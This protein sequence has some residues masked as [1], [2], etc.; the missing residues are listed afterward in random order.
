[1]SDSNAMPILNVDVAII[2]GGPAGLMAAEVLSRAGLAVHLFDAMP[3]VGRKFLLAGKGGMNLTHAE[4]LETFVTRYGAAQDRVQALLQ[5]LGPP[6]VRDW[7][8]GLGIDDLRGHLEPRLP[9]RHES[10][11]PAARL[12]APAAPPG[13]RAV[14]RWCFTCATAGKAG[15]RRRRTAGVRRA[16]GPG[17][18]A[19]PRHRAR[20]G[21]RQ[22][23]PPGVRWCLGAMA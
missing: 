4:P 15:R 3:S 23:G 12:A 22:L 9:H 19:S 5:H 11:A 14:C 17:A 6:A 8:A 20:P 16:V 7:A 21:R 13:R 2:G 18:G 1:M 10:R